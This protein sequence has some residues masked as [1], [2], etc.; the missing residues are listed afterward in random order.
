MKVLIGIGV[1][2]LMLFATKKGKSRGKKA[3]K[4]G[5]RY[6]KGKSGKQPQQA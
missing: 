1:L 6:D 2:V 3:E 5:P 4:K